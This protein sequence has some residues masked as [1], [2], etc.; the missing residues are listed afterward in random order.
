MKSIILRADKA[1]NLRY[2]TNAFCKMEEMTGKA[3]PQLT[4]NAGMSD[5][6]VMLFCGLYWEDNEL[7]EEKAGDIMDIVIQKDGVE[8]LTDQI[9]KAMSLA[10]GEQ[11]VLGKKKR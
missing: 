11:Q 8:H 7:T 3:V 9:S 2:S 6:R 1:R 10:M 5:L 4:E